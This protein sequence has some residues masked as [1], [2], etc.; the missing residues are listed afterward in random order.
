MISEMAQNRSEFIFAG[1]IAANNP[2][3][4]QPPGLHQRYQSS[5]FD[6]RH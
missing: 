6:T 5:M 3:Q 2:R 4:N 1:A